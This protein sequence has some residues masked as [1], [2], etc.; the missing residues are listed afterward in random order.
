[1]TT[2]VLTQEELQSIKEIQDK[3]R[4]LIEQFGV[5]ELTIQELEIQKQQLRTE[6]QTLKSKEIEVG[7]TLQNKYGE[8]TINVEKGEFISSN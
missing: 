1:M 7:S 3:R 5:I 2:K 8:G 4:D 6:L